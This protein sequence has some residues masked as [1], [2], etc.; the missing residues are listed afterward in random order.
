MTLHP[1]NPLLHTAYASHV[2]ELV[3]DL[4]RRR[5]DC[6]E[7]ALDLLDREIVARCWWRVLRPDQ[8][9]QAT[10]K[11]HGWRSPL[12][13]AQA[14]TVLLT[15]AEAGYPITGNGA[16]DYSEQE[17]PCTGA[18]DWLDLAPIRGAVRDRVL[19]AAAWYW[20]RSASQHLTY[21]SLGDARGF[22]PRPVQY[23]QPGSMHP[24][25]QAALTF[26]PEADRGDECDS[27]RYMRRHARRLVLVR[28]ERTDP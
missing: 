7:D 2:A 23:D 20:T 21:V 26:G 6:P 27:H 5:A 11:H 28:P 8:L 1:L 15:I 19:S 16:P 17:A 3:P 4:V 22:V 13:V 24:D 14:A 25:Q 10:L 9:A 18:P 12:S